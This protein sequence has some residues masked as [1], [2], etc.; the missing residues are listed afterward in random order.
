VEHMQ[1]PVPPMLVRGELQL[2]RWP[3]WSICCYSSAL[4]YHG[5]P[6]SDAASI[7]VAIWHKF[8]LADGTHD[9]GRGQA[10]DVSAPCINMM[11]K[12]DLAKHAQELGDAGI[13]K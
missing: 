8:E 2:A 11:S 5:H 3:H 13:S 1:S 4:G 12:E 9:I 7:G 10:P 6:A